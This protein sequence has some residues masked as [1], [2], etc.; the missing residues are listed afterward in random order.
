M[1]L[2]TM[3]PRSSTVTT[4]IAPGGR[5]PFSSENFTSRK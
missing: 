2:A 4:R 3:V 5:A 1:A